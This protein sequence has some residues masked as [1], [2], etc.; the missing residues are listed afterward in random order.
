MGYTLRLKELKALA[1]DLAAL[2]REIVVGASEG[3]VVFRIRVL[4]TAGA[5][6]AQDDA[7]E[8]FQQLWRK[9]FLAYANAL[10]AKRNL[11]ITV[12]DKVEW[13]ELR[14]RTV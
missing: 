8:V 3:E 1:E 13:V 6:G 7:E 5:P 11:P 2:D 14:V 12:E 9:I 10:K 4:P